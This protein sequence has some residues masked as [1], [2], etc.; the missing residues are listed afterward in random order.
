MNNRP[1]TA[2]CAALCSLAIVAS[3][4]A[5]AGVVYGSEVLDYSPGLTKNGKPI[6]GDHANPANALGAPGKNNNISYVSL[7]L[8]GSITI[9]FG[10]DF[11]DNVW[12]TPGTHANPGNHPASSEIFVGVGASW[13]RAAYFSL[14]RINNAQPTTLFGLA[15][16]NERSG[17]N[18]Y[19]FLRIEDRSDPLDKSGP[20]TASRSTASAP[21]P[22]P[23]P[24]PA[25]CSPWPCPGS[26][27]EGEPRSASI[28]AV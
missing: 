6:T 27:R 17:V 19:S 11:S 2:R 20:A 8:G 25:H 28:S 18:A 4:S 3:A 1:N 22:S 15:G 5:N 16:V 21:T 14:G 13:D 12:I 24:S 23:R 7:G 10:A 26:Q 9:S